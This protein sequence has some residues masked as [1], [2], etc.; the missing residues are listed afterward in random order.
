M[1]L[2]LLANPRSGAGDAEAVSG[3][4]RSLGADV[5]GAP[6]EEAERAPATGIERVAVAGGDG[7]IGPAAELA[8][9]AGVP[10][11]VIP[12]GTANDFA[13]ALGL[14]GTLEEACRLAVEGT[15]TRLMELGR[16]GE[17]PFVNVV[18]AGLPP[19]AAAEAHDWKPRLGPLAYALGAV[20][21]ALRSDPVACRVTCDG[22]ELF[23]G[24]AWQ[25]TVACTGSFGAGSSVDADPHDGRLH[26]VV[27]RAGSR[28]GLL[29]RA[30][31]LRSGRIRR[32]RGVHDR[33]ARRVRVEVVPDTSFNLDG[34]LCASGP[35]EFTI[36]HDAFEVLVP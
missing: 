23:D 32:Q 2:L 11:A 12:T 27:V 6:I 10:L 13:R 17:R 18:S 14:P 8:A 22:A 21:A 20:R 24:D 35:V 28:A 1:R 9:R 29:R 4:L 7:S 16:M 5:T 19:A 30:Y 3:E 34:E 26:A 31:G 15:R 25:V 36:E 33:R